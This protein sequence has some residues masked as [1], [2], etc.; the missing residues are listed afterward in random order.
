MDYLQGLIVNQVDVKVGRV[1]YTPLLNEAG[2]IVAD[3]TIIRLAHDRF[4][5]VDG[6]GMGMRDKKWFSDH[7]PADGSVQIH[8]QTSALYTLGV[9]GPRARD[10]VQSVTA[11]DLSAATS[12]SGRPGRSTSAGSGP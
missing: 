1:V 9:W 10:V 3:L 12:R 5:V 11:A 2:G 6:G 7:L 8:D 4:R